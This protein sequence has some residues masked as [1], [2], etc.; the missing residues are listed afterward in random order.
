[1]RR[2][3]K[4]LHTLGAAGLTGGLVALMVVLVVAPASIGAPGYASLVIAMAKIGGWVIGPSVLLTV[5]SG[6]LSLGFTPAFHNSLWAWAKAATGIA[7]FEGSLLVLGPLQA[8]AKRLALN[9]TGGLDPESAARLFESASA[10]LWVLFAI[11]V[12]NIALGVWRPRLTKS[13]V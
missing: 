9:Q 8:E 4:F 12:A 1:L 10:T 3:L 13:P 6:V 7:A 2:L 5:G 11:C